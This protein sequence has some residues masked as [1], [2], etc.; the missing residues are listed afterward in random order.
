MVKKSGKYPQGKKVKLTKEKESESE[1]DSSSDSESES[2]EEQLL[3]P[4]RGRGR[5]IKEA[6][7]PKNKKRKPSR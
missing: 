1:S 3:P 5:P 6:S 7:L 4:K 2:E